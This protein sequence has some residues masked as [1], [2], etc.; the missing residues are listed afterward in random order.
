M[1]PTLVEVLRSLPRADRATR[2]ACIMAREV[3]GDGA[4]C[5]DRHIE[6]ENGVRV[7]VD[8]IRRN[9]QAES[10]VKDPGAVADANYELFTNV[11]LPALCLPVSLLSLHT[12]R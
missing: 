3:K 12:K 4:I 10:S 7:P 6:V 5:G 11:I 8:M 9:M 2:F 1:P